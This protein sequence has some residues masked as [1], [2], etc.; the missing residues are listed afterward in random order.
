[1]RPAVWLLLLWFLVANL[2]L[3]CGAKDTGPVQPNPPG[4][5]ER[6]RLPQRPKADGGKQKP[7]GKPAP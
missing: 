5:A 1:M 3:G 7:A 2:G 6:G 4:P